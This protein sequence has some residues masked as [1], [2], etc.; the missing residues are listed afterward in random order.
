MITDIAAAPIM[1]QPVVVVLGPT[2]PSGG[3]TG[4]TGPLGTGPTGAGA[5]TG[6]TG[7]TG[8]GPTGP[9]GAGAFTG[10]T[11]PIGRTGPPGPAATGAQGALGPTGYTGPPGTAAQGTTGGPG[12]VFGTSGYV[13]L[14]NILIQWGFASGA[15]PVTVNL[16]TNYVDAAPVISLTATGATGAAGMYVNADGK[17]SFN[18]TAFPGGSPSIGFMWHT[19]GS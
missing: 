5:Y 16:W 4:P 17:T 19:I 13:Y 14:G 3:P 6:P 8:G 11:G 18:V 1:A 7:P 15:S 9:T 10:P 12:A 2:G